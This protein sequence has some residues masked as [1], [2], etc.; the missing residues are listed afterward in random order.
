MKQWTLCLMGLLAFGGIASSQAEPGAGGG[1]E[2]A[3]LA[4]ET[5]WLQAIKASNL[6]PVAANFDERFV[7]TDSSGVVTNKAQGLAELKKS[8][9]T[10]AEYE[11]VQVVVFG[12]TAIVTGGF[13]GKGTD[14]KGK[15]FDVHER[16]TDTWAK[17]KG[18][19]WLCV[20]S[21][22]STLAK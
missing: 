3:I 13:K 21:H 2:K 8:K 18:G 16:W 1:V 4:M 22:S 17:E 20:A 5:Q 15:P 10:V 7:N 11:N 19:K 12:D 9:F 6:D 14:D